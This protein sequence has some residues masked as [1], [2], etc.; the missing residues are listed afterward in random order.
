MGAA[1]LAYAFFTGRTPS[2]FIRADR[3]THPFLFWSDVLG[4]ALIT[5]VAAAL[6]AR[7]WFR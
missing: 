6:M 2:R 5:L 1:A 3:S 7:A 4:W